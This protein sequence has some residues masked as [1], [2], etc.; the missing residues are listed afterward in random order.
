[1]NSSKPTCS[2]G[3]EGRKEGGTDR[4]KERRGA[5]R[6]PAQNPST[7]LALFSQAFPHDFSNR[8]QLNPGCLG[9]P[10]G[11][12]VKNLPA[13]AGDT[14]L[15]PDLGRSYMP[16][17]NYSCVPQLLRLCSRAWEPKL[18]K[19]ATACAP[20]PEKPLQWEALIPQLETRPRSLQ[21]ENG[22]RS[23]KD[24]AQPKINKYIKLVVRKKGNSSLAVR[25]QVFIHWCT[26]RV[27]HFI[28]H[29]TD[30]FYP[31]WN[32]RENLLNGSELSMLTFQGHSFQ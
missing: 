19:P 4:R 10:G 5:G 11:L 7:A 27:S 8:K 2:V 29:R 25:A 23:N 31:I 24:Q 13:N 28:V 20:Q 18:L 16:W 15:I 21:L 17:G 6:K 12:V 14:S 1:M 3:R 22:P 32:L 30:T 9:F 26:H